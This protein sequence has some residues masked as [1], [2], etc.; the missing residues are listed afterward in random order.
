MLVE[1]VNAGDLLLQVVLDGADVGGQ[2]LRFGEDCLQSGL[3]AGGG[4]YFELAGQFVDGVCGVKDG[5]GQLLE[6][7]VRAAF[8][9]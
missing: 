4:G 2:L 8:G 3:V 1:V 9:G 5:L 7:R 6:A